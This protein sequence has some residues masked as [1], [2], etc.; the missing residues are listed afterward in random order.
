MKDY[1]EILG[2]SRDASQDEIKRAYRKRARHLHPDYAGAESED[3]F[4]ELSAA[5]E[6]LSDS[7][8]RR[9]YDLGGPDAVRGA[10][11]NFGAGDYGFA[12]LF[13]TMF[14]GMGGGF[15]SSRGPV[16]RGRRGRDSLLAVELTLEEITFGATKDL[17][18]DTAILCEVCGGSCCEPG[19]SPETCAVCGG[20][21]S[22]VRLQQSLLGTIRTSAACQNCHGHGQVIPS[23]CQECAGDGRVY[24]ARTISVDIPAG[25]E[26]GTRIRLRGEGEVGPGGGPA[27]DLYL[28]VRQLPHPIFARSGYDLYTRIDVPMTMAALGSRFV[29][30]TFDGDREVT[31][32]A[33]TQSGEEILLK[34]LGV[35]RPRGGR[36]DLHVTVGVETPRKLDDQQR[37]LL[38]ELAQ[39]RGEERAEPAGAGR[40][41]M[42]WFKDKLGSQ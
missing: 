23:P 29:L 28:E 13:E 27:G 36:G 15:A 4:K 25:A 39:L 33:G 22:V 30:T 31:V 20:T 35:G 6:V 37:H 18:I 40:G 34:G 41:P 26:D 21:G 17:Q 5:Y 8:K 32:Q 11:S 24:T 7:Q 2:V 10:G 3:A 9:A 42:K 19:T 16:P 38:E 12:D 1:Y 14:G